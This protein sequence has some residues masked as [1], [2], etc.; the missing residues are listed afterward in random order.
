VW[1]YSQRL[2]VNRTTRSQ[3]D[4]YQFANGGWLDSTEIPDMYSGYTVYHQVNKEVELA[5]QTIINNAADSPGEP[6]CESQQVGDVFS[7]F[8][9]VE[10]INGLG[11]E[12]VMLDLETIS[13]IDSVESLTRV[14]AELLRGGKTV[15]YGVQISPSLNDS[16]QYSVYVGQDGITMPDRD[17]YLDLDNEKFEKAR[18]GLVPYIAKMLVRSGLDAQAAQDA[19]E[20]IYALETEIARAQ[21]DSVR[22]RDPQNLNNPYLTDDLPNLGKNLRWSSSLETLGMHGEEKI[23]VMTPSYFEALDGLLV[24]SP[25][26][27]WKHY[28][29]FRILDGAAPDERVRIW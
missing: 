24:S 29:A 20:N 5:L 8:M 16:S 19:A 14:M 9:D 3:D 17:Y 18:Q 25:L 22:L 1:R 27:T 13:N 2:A 21:W 23:I 6:G 12:P 7:S 4:F 15:P 11:I 28:L 26:E 10:T